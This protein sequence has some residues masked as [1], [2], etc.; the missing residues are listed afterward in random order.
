MLQRLSA[1]DAADAEAVDDLRGDQGRERDHQRQPVPEQAPV[2]RV[3][4]EVGDAE[5]GVLVGEV[6]PGRRLRRGR[7]QGRRD[8]ARGSRQDD[9]QARVAH[10]PPMQLHQTKPQPPAGRT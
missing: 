6:A 7:Q 4:D 9:E 5:D 10:D 8:E 3:T 1:D 2:G